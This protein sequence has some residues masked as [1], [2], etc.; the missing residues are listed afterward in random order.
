MSAE[1]LDLDTG[2]RE[3]L[4]AD[5]RV[6]LSGAAM[7]SD[8]RYVAFDDATA[9][10]VTVR[11]VTSGDTVLQ[12]SPTPGRERPGVRDLNRDGSLLLYGGDPVEVWD[13][14]AGDVV[15]SFDRQE[16][17]SR[18]A[19]F[20][21][22]GRAVVSTDGGGNVR[23]WD[24]TTGEQLFALAA[25]GNGRASMSADGLILVSDLGAN[26]AVLVD[27]GLRGEAGAVETCHGDAHPDSLQIVGGLAAFHV[28]C[29]GDT[30]GTTY[31]VD[32]ASGE[33]V[34]T[35]P[36]HQGRGLGVSPDGTRLVRQEGEGA[37]PGP[38]VVR[39]LRTGEEQD[40]LA[41][42]HAFAAERL[43]WSPDGSMIVAKSSDGVAVW[44]A[45]S[46]DRL[47][48]LPPDLVRLAVRDVLFTPDSGRLLV[49]TGDSRLRA[50][51]TAT[52][53]VV[54]EEVYPVRANFLGLLGY[55][56][57]GGTLYTVGEYLNN[58]SG[59]LGWVDADTFAMPRSEEDIHEGSV[60]A[61]AVSPDGT[62]IATGASDG[63]V[64]VWDEA[65]GD[66]VHEVPFGD[67]PVQ[68][69]AFVDDTH[70]AVTPEG[71]DLL[72]VTIDRDELLDLV[73]ASLTR[74]FTE[75]ECERFTFGD[76]CPT[77]AE[78]RG[79]ARGGEGSSALDGVYRREWTSDEVHAA[80]VEAGF[81]DD[82]ASTFASGLAGTHTFTFADGR[83]DLVLP[84]RVCT[85]TYTTEGDRVSLSNER[86][87]CG[88]GKLFDATFTVT[89]GVL[90]FEDFYGISV[91]G[92][93]TAGH[94]MDKIE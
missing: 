39:D 76:D 22:S 2:E 25:V 34:R 49:T 61:M 90:L 48:D 72:F 63:F 62:R 81:S 18:S 86:G 75:T 73:S 93:F 69:V 13:V 58:T 12:F 46:G 1:L 94:P 40:T 56:P 42:P 85:G 50:V 19:R 83:Y 78:L 5:T 11:D 82:V 20:D 33:L 30:T 77:L 43:R 36:G 84:S 79:P 15:T 28:T 80:F 41:G 3:L 51:S 44:D 45:A 74:G 47:F 8:G 55:S 64:R 38:L 16:G 54:A 87:I 70:L 10:T 9:G 24:A 92:A 21:P 88:A 68:G 66:L 89:D 27:T 60:Q 31:V 52:W 57:D 7:S 14:A 67:T 59:T 6:D 35:L 71:G 29:G 26:A 32:V 23:R 37:E 17:A 53:E 65:T 91:V 4:A